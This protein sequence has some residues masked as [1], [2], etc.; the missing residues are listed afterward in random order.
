MYYGGCVAPNIYYMGQSG[1][2][3]VKFGSETLT[4]AGIS[5]QS[6]FRNYQRGYFETSDYSSALHIRE[7][8][9]EKLKLFKNKVDIFLSY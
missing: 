2:I 4:I 5:G 1:V 8:D 7:F 6:N 3:D 9:V